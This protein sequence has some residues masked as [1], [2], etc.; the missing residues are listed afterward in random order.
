MGGCHAYGATVTA[1]IDADIASASTGRHNSVGTER[2]V[3]RTTE[4]DV[5]V[6]VVVGVVIATAATAATDVVVIIVWHV[7]IAS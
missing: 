5:I 1:I 6:E 7:I 2:V 4:G 3:M